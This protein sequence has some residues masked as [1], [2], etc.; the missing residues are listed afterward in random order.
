MKFCPTSE[1]P[2]KYSL[3]VVLIAVVCGDELCCQMQYPIKASSGRAGP[4]AQL[5][6][7]SA[8][9][10]GGPSD[11]AA[12]SSS[13]CLYVAINGVEDGRIVAIGLAKKTGAGRKEQR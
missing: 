7:G 9:Q 6:P 5:L 13:K 12:C 2:P 4:F 1:L 11:V 3:I 10:S 8:K